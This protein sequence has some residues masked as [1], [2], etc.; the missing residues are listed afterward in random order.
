MKEKK[1][2][3]KRRRYALERRELKMSRTKT[4]YMC[5]NGGDGETIRLQGV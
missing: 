4:E 5:L 1:R 3:L 2:E